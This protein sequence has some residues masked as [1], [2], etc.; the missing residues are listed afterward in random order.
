M[1]HVRNNLSLKKMFINV[2]KY[3]L[4]SLTM[5]IVVNRI[6]AMFNLTSTFKSILA[7]ASEIILGTIIYGGMLL[8]MKPT[9]LNKL[10][11]IVKK[12]RSRKHE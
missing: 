3:A 9:I 11:I 12:I 8:L 7:I 1:W 5:F 4:A 10:G 2:P 6:C